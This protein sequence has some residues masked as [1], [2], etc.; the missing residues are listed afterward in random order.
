MAQWV[1][2]QLIP[3]QGE[4]KRGERYFGPS[5]RTAPF[6]KMKQQ[7]SAKGQ[8]GQADRR[9]TQPGTYDRTAI[10]LPKHHQAGRQGRVG[11]SIGELPDEPKQG[12]HAA[13]QQKRLRSPVPGWVVTVQA[14]VHLEDQRRHWAVEMI[15]EG[16][17]AGEPGQGRAP[18]AD[19][20]KEHRGVAV[21]EQGWRRRPG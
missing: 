13:D 15:F 2:N 18:L 10:E 8:G 5:D 11:G 19:R 9:P 1:G 21:L 16:P 6:T 14:R 3:Q 17:I 4:R 12:Q 7:P 20:R